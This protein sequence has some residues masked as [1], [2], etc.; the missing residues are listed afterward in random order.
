[1]RSIDGGKTFD[2][3]R[4]PHGDTHILWIDPKDNRRMIN[5]N[6]GGA[7]ISFDKGA[8][9]STMY[10]Q[11]T[12]QFYHVTTDTQWPY[13]IYGAQQDNS[14][15]SVVSRS[16]DGAIGE[17]DYYSV[18]GC[19]NATI[20]VDPRDPLVTY[21]GCY[22]G[23]FSRY[24]HRSRQER[25]VP[26]VVRIVGTNA[27]EAGRLLEEARFETAATLDEAAAKAVAAARA[28]SGG[29][30]M[31]AADAAGATGGAA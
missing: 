9:W 26:M 27:E 23:S 8:S 10:N 24:D 15:V 2:V 16:D 3:V 18:A 30:G 28:A 5:G 4:V 13:R 19:E 29:S 11:P 1:M 17:R 25:D 6:D 7:V 22:M 20:A 31:G 14:A 21:G 12:A